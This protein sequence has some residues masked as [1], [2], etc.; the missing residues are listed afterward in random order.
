MSSDFKNAAA[1]HSYGGFV[2]VICTYCISK[3]GNKGSKFDGLLGAFKSTIH[4][5]WFGDFG[6]QQKE[7]EASDLSTLGYLLFF[8]LMLLVLIVSL[9]A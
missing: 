3:M 9:N 4:M 5:S 1:T 8:M 2:P 7:L 6:D